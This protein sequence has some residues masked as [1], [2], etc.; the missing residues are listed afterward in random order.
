M[1]NNIRGNRQ[2]RIAI[3]DDGGQGFALKTRDGIV[4]IEFARLEYVEV[5]DKTVSFHFTDGL[6]REVA[7][8]LADFEDKL[9]ARPEF[10]KVHRSYLVNLSHVQ[11]VGGGDILTELGHTIPVARQRR[12]QVQDAYMDFLMHKKEKQEEASEKMERAGGP[13]NILLVDDE[14]DACLAWINILRSHGCVVRQAVNGGEA[15]EKAADGVYDCVLLDV[16]LQGENGFFLCERLH[17]LTQAPVIFL[18]SLTG[19][20]EQVKGF[21]AGGADYITKDTPAGLF[22]AKV[23]TRIRLAA[24]APGHTRYRYGPLLLEL[25][26]RKVY[27]EEKELSLTPVEFDLLWQLSERAG[28]IFTPKELFQTIWGGQPWDGGQR[29]QMHMSRLRR[30]LEKAWE[31]HLFIETV[32]G[33]GY[34]FVLPGR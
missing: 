5:V 23:E 17:E 13:W 8:A 16:L 18:S 27:L 34:R 7:A 19:T 32:W 14:P 30:K 12:S 1:K 20:D 22:W 29:V 24:S 6:I 15:L 2:M 4:R 31:E 25:S 21:E 26:E 11:A 10:L 33:Q 9:L 3:C 28:H